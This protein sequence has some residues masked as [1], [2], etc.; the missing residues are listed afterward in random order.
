VRVVAWT[1]NAQETAATYAG[2]LVKGIWATTGRH[3]G[4]RLL[5]TAY[6][7]LIVGTGDGAAGTTAHNRKSLAGK[8]LRLNRFTGAPWP[9]NPWIRSSNAKMRYVLTYG[10]RNVQGL[11]RR[12]NGT[13]WSVEHGPTRDDEVNQLAGGRDFGWNPVPGYN[14]SVPM[15]DHSLPGTQTSA[16]W[17][18]GSPTLATSGASWV[19]GARWGVYDGTL[20]VAALKGERVLFMTFTSGGKLSSV[21]TPAALR[22]HGRLRSVTRL[23]NG[24]LLVT[25]SNGGGNDSILRVRPVG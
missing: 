23:G 21:R 8:T 20:A 13:I 2:T 9:H 5:I 25:T 11:A 15:T 10:H 7:A 22:S 24:D 12:S 6:G 17:R 19:Y 18:S 3:G 4:C 1:L 14:E 16:R